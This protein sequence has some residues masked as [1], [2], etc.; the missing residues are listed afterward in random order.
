MS[1]LN[2]SLS[3]KD[4]SWDTVRLPILQILW[5][6]IHSANLDF[7]SLNWDEFEWQIVERSSRPS[8]MSKLMYTCFTKLI[9]NHF[10]SNNNSIPRRSRS[11]LHSSQD[12]QPITKLSNTVKGDYMFG[13]EILDTMISDAIKKLAGYKY[14][15]A[16][17]V[18]SKKAKIVDEPEEQHVSPVK[19]GR[20]KGFICYG[21]QVA[22]V[23]NK[24]K[25]D[26]VPRKTRSLTIVEEVVVGELANSISIQEPR[27]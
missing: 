7:A 17:K 11:K 20:G 18:E 22:N 2:R 23:P 27:I 21:D 13:M 14:Y 1:V 15:M 4:S 3:G 19:S 10:L 24:L 25:K 5:D 16:K 26:V 8:N 6:I 12:D 9:I